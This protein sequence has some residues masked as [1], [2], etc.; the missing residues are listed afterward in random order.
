M[1]TIP[2]E[3]SDK[4]NKIKCKLLLKAFELISQGKENNQQIPKRI[5][6]HSHSII[7][8][9]PKSLVVINL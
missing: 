9:F 4:I 2:N 6:N 7:N 1:T 3:N 5:L 8:H